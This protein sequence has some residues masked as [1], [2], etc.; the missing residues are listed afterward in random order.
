MTFISNSQNDAASRELIATLFSRWRSLDMPAT[1]GTTVDDWDATVFR[2]AVCFTGRD[3]ASDDA[4]LVRGHTVIIFG[5]KDDTIEA[6][7]DAH[8][9]ASTPDPSVVALR[10]RA[11]GP[12][13]A[14]RSV[15]QRQ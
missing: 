14:S 15:L 2:D 11:R 6:I 4:Y 5:L 12:R 7:Y 8:V 1:H 3:A 13:A 9:V 10:Q